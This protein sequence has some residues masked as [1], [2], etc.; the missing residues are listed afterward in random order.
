MVRD[1]A[2]LHDTLRDL[3]IPSTARQLK[4]ADGTV[5]TGRLDVSERLR[6]WVSWRTLLCAAALLAGCS[7]TPIQPPAPG[8]T[9][10]SV[11][12]RMYEVHVE[13]QLVAGGHRYAAARAA[14]SAGEYYDLVFI[15]GVLGCAEQAGYYTSMYEFRADE[16][17]WQRDYSKWEWVE[18]A[19][20]LDYLASRLRENCGLEPRTPLRELPSG[21]ADETAVVTVAEEPSTAEQV[22]GM[23]VGSVLMTAW[24]VYGPVFAIGDGAYE[25]Y[26]HSAFKSASGHVLMAL[27]QPEDVVRKALGPADV[28]FE[29]P[30]AGT[31]VLAYNPKSS[32][33]LY[34]GIR[35]GQAVWVH[36]EY[37]WLD[38]LAERAAGEKKKAAE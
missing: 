20:G 27:P 10:E 13:Y 9:P 12:E 4:I 24:L 26:V 1:F 33:S 17:R 16:Y 38:E 6:P 25:A 35:E 21:H 22:G 31:V 19:D 5:S 30:K 3:R 29:L 2:V 23:L 28:R 7:T 18:E 34:V 36:G 11:I 14:S 15:D 8:E 37:P 32:R